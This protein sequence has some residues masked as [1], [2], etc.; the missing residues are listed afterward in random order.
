MKVVLAGAVGLL[1]ALPALA[2]SVG[3]KTG[4]NSHPQRPTS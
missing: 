4:L 3:E 2:Q 1:I